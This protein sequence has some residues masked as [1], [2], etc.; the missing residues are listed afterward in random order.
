MS[1]RV[2]PPPTVTPVDQWDALGEDWLEQALAYTAAP[3]R[4]A[5][6]PLTRIR[7]RPASRAARNRGDRPISMAGAAGLVYRLAD[8]LDQHGRAHRASHI[9]PAEFWS[10]AGAHAAPG[11]LEAA[12]P[13]VAFLLLD[14]LG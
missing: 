3:S 8:Y 7:P 13:R 14:R 10:A 4:D 2:S 5:R 9:P 1:D 11:D 12:S 6:G